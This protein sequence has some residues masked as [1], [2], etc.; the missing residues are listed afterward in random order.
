MS[1]WGQ[2]GLGEE[3][4]REGRKDWAEPERAHHERKE[5]PEGWGG[6]PQ[7]VQ[8]KR[9]GKSGKCEAMCTQRDEDDWQTD[10]SKRRAKQKEGEGKHFGSFRKASGNLSEPQH[11]LCEHS[12]GTRVHLYYVRS[13]TWAASH[14]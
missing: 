14:Q 13:Q 2:E 12:W 3:K 11:S 4:K 1:S 6:D 10:S 5:L 9:K 8:T 7:I